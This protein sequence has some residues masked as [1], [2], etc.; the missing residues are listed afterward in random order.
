M[1]DDDDDDGCEIRCLGEFGCDDAAA[2][3]MRGGVGG[4]RFSL[5]EFD[6]ESTFCK[7]LNKKLKTKLNMPLVDLDCGG[8]DN[9]CVGDSAAF[10]SFLA[11][12]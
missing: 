11:S 12:L 5:G 4:V 9:G 7:K 2:V 10:D 1:G 6:A 3:A 8:C